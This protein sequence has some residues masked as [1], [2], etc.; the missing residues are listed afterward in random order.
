VL[1]RLLNRIYNRD[2]SKDES[3]PEGEKESQQVEETAPVEA[4]ALKSIDEK[5][6]EAPSAPEAT[7]EEGTTDSPE[8]EAPEEDGEPIDP[9]V[10]R[11]N[12]IEA[13]QTVYDPE[14]PLNIY[15]IGLIYD[16]KV[17][18]SGMT[19]VIMTLTSPAC[20]AA[21][22]LPGEVE[23]KTRSVAGVK[24]V[25][26]DLT[27]EPPWTPDKMTEAAKLELGLL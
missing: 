3:S 12:I 27:F 14:I 15:E 2:K 26:L 20:P 21:G 4:E 8:T 1:Q 13:L 19:E 10:V 22:I 11:E 16:V 5:K 6:Q 17:E 7:A 25:K 23:S 18:P 9:K 24:D